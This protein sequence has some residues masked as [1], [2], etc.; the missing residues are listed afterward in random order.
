MPT[1]RQ[2][3]IDAERQ[4]SQE[5][6]EREA[7]DLRSGIEDVRGE[8]E[9]LEELTA[10]DVGLRRDGIVVLLGGIVLTTWPTWWSE[11]VLGWLTWPAVVHRH[12]RVLHR[13]TAGVG[14][15]LALRRD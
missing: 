14:V 15:H 1:L 2:R 10:G 7:K 12:G 5:A 4:R 13:V 6:L 9:R 11:N 3:A 8:L